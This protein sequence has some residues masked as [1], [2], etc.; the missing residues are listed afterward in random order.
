MS[1]DSV[2]IVDNDPEDY[3]IAQEIWRELAIPHELIHLGSADEAYDLLARIETAPFIIICDANLPGTNG[4][5]FRQRL[6]DTHSKKFKSVPFIFWSSHATEGQITRA[7]NLS[8]HG[9]FVKEGTYNEWKDTFGIIV[10][11]WLKSK[12]PDKNGQ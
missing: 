12:M 8:A 3:E 9:F 4:F 11:Y 1:S 6:L 10:R 5:E 7:F 2:W